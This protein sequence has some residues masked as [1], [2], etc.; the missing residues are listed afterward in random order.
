MRRCQGMASSLTSFMAGFGIMPRTSFL[1]E[2]QR[3]FMF[4]L[5]VSG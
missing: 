2:A 3:I 1:A 5:S 4:Q